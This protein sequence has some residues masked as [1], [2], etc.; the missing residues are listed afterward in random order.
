M[1]RRFV[2]DNKIAAR[3]HG[4]RRDNRR[5]PADRKDEI[6]S[7]WAVPKPGKYIYFIFIF[8]FRFN[9]DVFLVLGRRF[10]FLIFN[11]KTFRVEVLTRRVP[12][13]PPAYSR[14]SLERR[15]SR[16]VAR[17][18]RL[19]AGRANSRFPSS[20][21][22]DAIGSYGGVRPFPEIIAVRRRHQ[23]SRARYV[24]NETLTYVA[25]G[26]IRRTTNS[27]LDTPPPGAASFRPGKTNVYCGPDDD[28]VEIVRRFSLEKGAL[29]RCDGWNYC[30]TNSTTLLYTLYYTYRYAFR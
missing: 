14:V 11:S 29:G 12:S 8:F 23:C 4:T 3:A 26:F 15:A 20:L 7:A 30:N 6:S 22:R 27:G 19:S 16:A 5:R 18:L 25:F 1:W 24:R 2:R 10:F 13:P 21:V 28:G 17:V 9:A